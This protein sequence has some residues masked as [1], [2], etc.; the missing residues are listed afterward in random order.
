M[1]AKAIIRQL[2]LIVF[3]YCG[4]VNGQTISGVVNSY[5]QV[6]AINT[7]SNTV[8]LNTTSGLGSGTKVLIIQMKG[9][10]INSSNNSSFGD[11]SAI[12]DAGNYEFNYICSISGNDVLLQY[13]LVNAYDPTQTVQLVS[14]PVYNSVTISGTLTASSWDPVSG[15]GGIVALEATNTIFLNNNI[16]VSGQGFQ[17]GA[18]LNYPEP[19]PYDCSYFIPISDFYT[20]VPTSDKYHT[21]GKKGE[22]IAAYI[23][24]KDYG[25]GKQANGGGGGN[26]TNTGGAGGGNYGAGGGGGQRTNQTGFQCLGANPGVGGL[27]LS[28]YGYSPAQNRIFLGGGGGSGQENNGVGEPGGNGGGIVILTAS[29]ITAGGGSIFA[30]GISPV[31][32]ACLDPTKAEGDGGG[33]GGGGGA[34]ILNVTT[35]SGSITIQANGAK[36]SDASNNITNDCTGPGG[37]GGGGAIWASGAVFPGAITASV[38]GGTNGVIAQGKAACTGSSNFAT[39][40]NNG[41]TAT[42]YIAP[43]GTIP[44]C[45]VLP[46]S[47]LQYFKGKLTDQGAQLNWA[48]NTVDDV[49]DYKVE[50]SLDNTNYSVTASIDNTGEKSLS[51]TD[52][53]K[54]DGTIYYRLMLEF[55][56]GSTSYSG[57]VALSRQVDLPIS[58]VSLQP[59]PAD[60]NLYLVVFAKKM[61]QF[62][63]AI[64]NTY[65]QRVHS[66]NYTL[67]SG[68]TTLNISLSNMAPGAY[69][70]QMKGRDIEMVKS[71]IKKQ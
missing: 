19:S 57:V 70:L 51:Y 54:T 38:S 5:Y 13:Q 28:T 71:F 24:S 46:I 1:I 14:V 55:K 31:N 32:A 2:L 22:G 67:N 35:V 53:H 10:T 20:S 50:S 11:I 12:G 64:Y 18:L 40:G 7:I 23:T 69:F 48:M 39:A 25:K 37:G 27:A 65:G 44:I 60:E 8:T 47:A 43:M 30:N 42:G 52:L 15:T 29:A 26:A 4:T 9:A 21:G 41:A 17:G 33:G 34:V 16:D 58:L 49:L 45:S 62:N 3:F 68:N 6:T 61:E 56:N 36:G 59:N 66:F 63:I